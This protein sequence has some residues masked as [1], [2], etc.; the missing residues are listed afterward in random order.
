MFPGTA[1]DIRANGLGREVSRGAMQP[2]SQ[3]GTAPKPWGICRQSHEHPLR[4]ILR[5]V[6]IA[7]HAQR[8]GINKINVPSHQFG[9]RRFR[10][11]VGVLAQKLLVGQTVHSF[12]STLRRSN[13][14]RR[15]DLNFEL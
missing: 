15:T 1:A 10:P 4:H 3:H 13:R 7:Q 9:K 5:Q 11:A 14:T 6:R 2:P 8:C 12:E